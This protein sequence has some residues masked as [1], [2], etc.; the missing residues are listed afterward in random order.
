[1][2]RRPRIEPPLTT[3]ECANYIGVTTEFIRGA[4]AD[5]E[6]AAEVVTS[7]GRRLIRV[8]VDHFHAY[9]RRIGWR[10]VPRLE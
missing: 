8:H 5:G 10:R 3:R 4:I 9:L 6:L 2:R 1:M 7:G